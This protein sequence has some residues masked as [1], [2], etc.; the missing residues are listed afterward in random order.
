MMYE[1]VHIT[2]PSTS[3]CANSERYVIC[4]NFKKVDNYD[5]YSTIYNMLVEFKTDSFIQSII[6]VPIPLHISNVLEEIN[7]LLAQ[8]QIE[9]INKTISYIKHNNIPSS[10]LSINIS[11]CIHWC[12]KYNI[13][14]NNK[15]YDIKNIRI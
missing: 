8:N 3:R 15:V 5:Y 12:N 13:H 6:N 1:D 2:K 7:T 11:K 4:L 9:Y 10:L 14:I